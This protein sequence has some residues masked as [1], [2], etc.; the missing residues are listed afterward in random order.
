MAVAI[1]VQSCGAGKKPF[2]RNVYIYTC[3]QWAKGM[4]KAFFTLSLF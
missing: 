3:Q 1:G 2:L 4:R